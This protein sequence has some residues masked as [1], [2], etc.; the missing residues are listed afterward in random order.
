MIGGWVDF[1]A[2]VA[3]LDKYSCFY[4]EPN[5]KSSFVHPIA[6]SEL[7]ADKPTEHWSHI[8]RTPRSS[9][10]LNKSELDGIV[11][12]YILFRSGIL[13]SLQK[14]NWLTF[15]QSFA[16]KIPM[17]DTRLA[18]H[19][20]YMYALYEADPIRFLNRSGSVHNISKNCGELTLLQLLPLCSWDGRVKLPI[21]KYLENRE[22]RRK[23]VHWFSVCRELLLR[24]AHKPD[25]ANDVS[26]TALVIRNCTMFQK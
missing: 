22:I 5:R 10:T 24:C 8:L 23:Y 13:L 3:V 12:R 2:N 1:G 11:V 19:T 21:F 15:F 20:L 4:L 9:G 14:M 17:S 7:G 26:L 25:Y 6:S 16:V 18:N